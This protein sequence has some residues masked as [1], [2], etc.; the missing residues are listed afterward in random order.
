MRRRRRD[1]ILFR[2]RICCLSIPI[3]SDQKLLFRFDHNS[4]ARTQAIGYNDKDCENRKMAEQT[5][6][7]FQAGLAPLEQ[8][9]TGIK[10]LQLSLDFLVDTANVNYQDGLAE[11]A[12][13]FGY[14]RLW[15]LHPTQK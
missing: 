8:L 9:A 7:R 6:E 3:K 1:L 14:V 2:S 15:K 13:E 11:L 10:L 12:G 5:S 4:F